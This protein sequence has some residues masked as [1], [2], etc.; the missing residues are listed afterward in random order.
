MSDTLAPAEEMEVRESWRISLVIPM[1]VRNKLWATM[2]T[3]SM[4]EQLEKLA[5]C[6]ASIEVRGL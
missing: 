1:M 6:Y 2:K 4:M 3:R 5:F